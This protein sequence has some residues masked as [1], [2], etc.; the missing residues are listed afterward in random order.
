MCC[1]K[2]SS[3]NALECCVTLRWAALTPTEENYAQIEKE[4]LAI[5]VFACEKFD[6]FIYGSDS[7]RIQTDHKHLESIFQ[8][9][10]CV[11]LKRLQTMLSRFLKYDLNVTYLKGEFMLF[12]DTLSQAH[13]PEV[14][15]SVFV[16]ES[17]EVDH[18]ANL[19][20]SDVRWQQVTHA[21]A[22]D[23][24]LKQLRGVIEVGWPGGKSDV[25]ECL[26]P[27]FDLREVT[28]LVV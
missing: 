17:E 18:I 13:L 20:V 5:V 3:D 12:A 10:L 1:T 15:A 21:S 28:M 16:Q 6:A 23:P 9:E 8:K 2:A 26:R 27:Y 22:N 11:A 19:P 4:L 14:N 24:V 7:V 25:S